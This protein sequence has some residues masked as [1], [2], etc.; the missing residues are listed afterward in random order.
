M[1]GGQTVIL[2]LLVQ[3]RIGHR[4]HNM[5][6]I[7]PFSFILLQCP[8]SLNILFLSQLIFLYSISLK[9]V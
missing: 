3:T 7:S 4:L 5:V 2:Q 8:L 9:R 1:E 6:S